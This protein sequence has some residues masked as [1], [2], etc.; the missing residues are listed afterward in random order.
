[1]P[2]C[3]NPKCREDLLMKLRQKISWKGAAGVVGAL[4]VAMGLSYTA[5][6]RG[7]DKIQK[8]IDNNTDTTQ[9]L[10]VNTRVI[11]TDLNYIKMQMHDMKTLEAQRHEKL[12]EQ[13]EKLNE[14]GG[15]N[16]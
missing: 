13:L 8:Q 12:M 1:M 4:T 16:E 10:K 9:E 15:D 2:E 7:Q 3:P 11:E 14:K 6:S 5:Y